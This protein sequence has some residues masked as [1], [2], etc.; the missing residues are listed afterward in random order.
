MAFS[1]NPLEFLKLLS[2][3]RQR[4][5]AEMAIWLQQTAA[6]AVILA[7]KWTDF[8]NTYSKGIIDGTSEY[9]DLWTNEPH[10]SFM[11]TMMI[12]YLNLQCTARPAYRLAEYYKQASRVFNGRVRKET[13]DQYSDTVA[14]ILQRRNQIKLLYISMFGDGN[15]PAHQIESVNQEKWQEFTTAI[16][17]LNREAAALEVLANAFSASK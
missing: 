11:T 7:E 1:L 13:L 5:K 3:N 4:N 8:K 2:E 15:E 14:N 6:D 10:D 16:D 17:M 9:K 12:Y